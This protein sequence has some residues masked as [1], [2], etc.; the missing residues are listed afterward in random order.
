MFDKKIIF[1]EEARKQ[2]EILYCNNMLPM[3]EDESLQLDPHI[4]KFGI[5][6]RGMT[7]SSKAAS[8]A[9]SNVI[10]G[11]MEFDT[12]YNV[13]TLQAGQILLLQLSTRANEKVVFHSNSA[14]NMNYMTTIF[15]VENGQPRMVKQSQRL[16]PWFDV[17]SFISE[18]GIYYIRVDILSGSGTF[19]C[20]AVSLAK[21]DAQ[22]AQ[23]PKD[24]LYD[25]L[26]IAP[27]AKIE[28][29][30]FFDNRMDYDFYAMT[31]AAPG[32]T[33]VYINF[34][35]T[36]ANM[37]TP[38]RQNSRVLLS[39]YQLKN[40]NISSVGASL[41]MEKVLL[42]EKVT[43]P[44]DGTYIFA[45]VPYDSLPPGQL[46]ENYQFSVDY[47]AKTFDV[48]VSAE[49]SLILSYIHGSIDDGGFDDEELAHKYWRWVNGTS[50]H[51][52]GIVEHWDG[53]E[54][55]FFIRVVHKGYPQDK[56]LLAMGKI[57]AGGNF[58]IAIPLFKTV[59][60]AASFTYHTVMMD[61]NIVQFFGKDGVADLK[62]QEDELRK[63]NEAKPL[64]EREMEEQLQAQINQFLC[65]DENCF[66]FERHNIKWK[67]ALR[68]GVYYNSSVI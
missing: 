5:A 20:Q 54:K 67:G 51:A 56:P 48:D 43:L 32:P 19:Y 10:S 12:N 64:E 58:N 66:C 23:E 17:D 49:T 29:V 33:D 46:E 60:T 14:E 42:N 34:S 44:G 36:L 68:L 45:L 31:V 50:F 53:T 8:T 35:Y 18:G 28:A 9:N 11:V 55:D 37:V 24:N 65:E 3:E 41:V 30:S 62:S 2:D 59:P 40:N 13:G 7:R 57:D 25:A 22:D 4:G 26:S 38:T 52:W 21:Y 61:E 27:G 1:N 15:C 16:L 63:K 6:S 39:I 47:A